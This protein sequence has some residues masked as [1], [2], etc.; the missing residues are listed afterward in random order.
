VVTGLVLL[1]AL[2]GHLLVVAQHLRH[3]LL[4]RMLP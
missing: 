2:V 4:R 1:A 3:G